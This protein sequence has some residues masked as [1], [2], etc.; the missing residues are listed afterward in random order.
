MTA[1]DFEQACEEAIGGWLWDESFSRLYTENVS[2][3]IIEMREIAN[4]LRKSE[5]KPIGTTREFTS[6]EAS[7]D[8]E[9]LE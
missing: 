2:L 6:L 8:R 3:G 4:V 9:S 1:R 5:G 7:K